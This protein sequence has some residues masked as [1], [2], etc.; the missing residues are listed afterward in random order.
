MKHI[1]IIT[2][3]L[4]QLS[5]GY[6]QKQMPDI[7]LDSTNKE[8]LDSIVKIQKRVADFFGERV[9]IYEFGDSI[10]D[11]ETN[12]KNFLNNWNTEF[13]NNADD[14][15]ILDCRLVDTISDSAK[16]NSYKYY[17]SSDEPVV[18]NCKVS[19]KENPRGNKTKEL[20]IYPEFKHTY[21]YDTLLL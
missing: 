11:C 1:L 9:S 12:F 18:Y 21:L 8:M 10:V 6:G 4:F 14:Y 13:I 3:F 7:K 15:K 5:F 2:I 19:H 20:F 17:F 16:Y